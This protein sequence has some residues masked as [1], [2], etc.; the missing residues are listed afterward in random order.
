MP[1][2][3]GFLEGARASARFEWQP[4]SQ[5]WLRSP[6]AES[7]V[8]LENALALEVATRSP[9]YL[10]VHAGAVR[11]RDRVLVLP[12]VSRAGKS[13]LVEA[14][15]R[16]GALYYS[17]EFAVF[18]P[19]GG[20]RPYPRKL[21]LKANPSRPQPIRLDPESLGWT[22]RLRAARLGWLLD[23]RFGKRDC[24]Q[25][26]SPGEALLSLFANAVAARTRARALFH[27]LS[28]ALIG[29][30]ALRGIRGEAEATA[31]WLMDWMSA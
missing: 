8:D 4:D 10:F 13:T 2:C 9:R 11:Y 20:I 6:G 14:L 7:F 23:C 17:D 1:P 28:R 24:L 5:L 19:D 29:V 3:G 26:I 16:R 27:S 15:V 30:P 18:H 22:P 12:G 31:A 21:C 25:P